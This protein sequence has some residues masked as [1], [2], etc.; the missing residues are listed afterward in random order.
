MGICLSIGRLIR[1]CCIE[2]QKIHHTSSSR[3][4]QLL[5]LFKEDCFYKTD[6]V[7]L[8]V[9]LRI[10]NFANLKSSALNDNHS[11]NMLDFHVNCKTLGR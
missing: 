3:I 7:L 10:P 9:C 2:L 5:L 1:W 6:N 4:I 11:L 8:V